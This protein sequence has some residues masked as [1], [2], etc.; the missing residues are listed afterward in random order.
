MPE[1]QIERVEDGIFSLKP[2]G[3]TSYARALELAIRHAQPK[4]TVVILGDFLDSSILSQEA[5]ALKASKDLKF[6]GI[7]S[8][9]GNPEYA[10]SICDETYLTSFEDP[11]AVAL[12]A[13]KSV[14]VL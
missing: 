13:I 3:G 4:T 6:V 14:V 1:I 10:N 2:G 7:V 9:V 8:S 5:L 11:T 12:I